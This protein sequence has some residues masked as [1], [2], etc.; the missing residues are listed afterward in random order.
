MQFKLDLC[1]SLNSWR[2]CMLCI[3]TVTLLPA[4][5][6]LSQIRSQSSDCLYAV[7]F[8]YFLLL[9]PAG[10]V[11]LLCSIVRAVGQLLT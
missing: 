8:L 10:I 2:I 5:L 1:I 3:L 6:S 11:R 4:R 9:T 7:C